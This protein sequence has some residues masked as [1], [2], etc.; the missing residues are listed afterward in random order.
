MVSYPSLFPTIE[1]KVVEEEKE[2]EEVKRQEPSPLTKLYD[3]NKLRSR[4]TWPKFV[5]DWAFAD[6]D[7]DVGP[8]A[9][10]K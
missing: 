1:E 3:G 10:G 6:D 7:D 5:G 9:K 4:H 8:C 2:E